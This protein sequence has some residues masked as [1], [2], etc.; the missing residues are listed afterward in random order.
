LNRILIVNADD[1]GRSEAVN[2]GVAE[3]YRRGIVTSASIVAN[4][5]A[6]SHAVT[7][8]KE[9]KGL[10]VGIH[11]A[12]DEYEPVLP[13]AAISSVVTPEGRFIDRRRLFLKMAVDSRTGDDLFREW[14]AQLSKVVKAGI[15][16][17]HLDGHG[18]CHAHPRVARRVLELAKRYG[19]ERVRLPVE[20]IAWRS[21][22]IS[23]SRLMDKMLVT[24]ACP[25]ARRMWAGKLRFPIR[26]YGFS[27]AGSVTQELVRRVADAAPPGVSELMVHVGVGNDEDDGFRT[28]YNWKGD[29]EAVTAFGKN[30][31]QQQFHITLEAHQQKRDQEQWNRA[32]SETSGNVI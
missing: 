24:I 8:A 7:I 14:D 20:P 28:G 26:F 12:A 23:P 19:I 6:F 5:P 31:F 15:E 22:R 21:E 1:F 27:E 2:L 17:T 9:L 18:H 10:E 32:S 4:A 13:R 16:L 29:L 25:P 3:G 11:L 30:E